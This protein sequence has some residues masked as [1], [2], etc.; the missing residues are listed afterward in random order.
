MPNDRSNWSRNTSTPF[1]ISSLAK[2]STHSLCGS[3]SQEYDINTLKVIIISPNEQGF[4]HVWNPMFRLHRTDAQ[5]IN[6]SSLFILLL[7]VAR[8][9]GTIANACTKL[10]I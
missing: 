10:M 9:A 7:G 1:L 3:S 5:F 6:L 2:L 4:V 8:H